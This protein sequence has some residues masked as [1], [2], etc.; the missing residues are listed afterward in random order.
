M[1]IS[2]V[3]IR[4]TPIR[5]L[6]TRLTRNIIQCCCSCLPTYLPELP[7]YLPICLAIYLTSFKLSNYLCTLNPLNPKPCFLQLPKPPSDASLPR[8]GRRTGR[9]PAAGAQGQIS[10]SEA[11]DV[12][13]KLLQ[14][15]Y[16]C[17]I[18][19]SNMVQRNITKHHITTYRT[20]SC[21]ITS[22]HI[23]Y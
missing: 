23:I 3:I 16:A 5:A 8:G 22:Y 17:K 11:V 2:R 10:A 20:V 14:K 21:N 13:H 9:I 12:L 4:V 15:S 18:T 1:V 7:T 19:K 6:I